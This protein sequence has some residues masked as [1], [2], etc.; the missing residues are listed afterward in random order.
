MKKEDFFFKNLSAI[1]LLHRK[2]SGLTREKLATLAGIS[3]SSIFDLE[4]EKKTIQ[5]DTLLK[6]LSVLNISIDLSSPLTKLT[7]SKDSIK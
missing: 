1:I 3:R 5:L 4:H 6:V 2:K 7:K